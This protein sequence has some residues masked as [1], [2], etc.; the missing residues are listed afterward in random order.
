M[1]LGDRIHSRRLPVV[2]PTLVRRDGGASVMT[3][4]ELVAFL[5]HFAATRDWATWNAIADRYAELG[6]TDGEAIALRIQQGRYWPRSIS[7]RWGD[8]WLDD[9]Q[10]HLR[11]DS[12][13]IGRYDLPFVVPDEAIDAVYAF[14]PGMPIIRR[15]PVPTVVDAFRRLIDGF[16]DGMTRKAK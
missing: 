9:Y 15:Y 12:Y 14:K 7:S 10:W 3:N 1:A 8:S 11:D 4:T 13:V 2:V 6:D 5:A 16:R